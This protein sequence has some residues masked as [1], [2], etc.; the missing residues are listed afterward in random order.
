MKISVY[1]LGDYG[2]NIKIEWMDLFSYWVEE[3]NK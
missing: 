2:D 1:V 3:F